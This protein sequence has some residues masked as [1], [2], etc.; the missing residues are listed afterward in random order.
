MTGRQVLKKALMLMDRVD[1]FGEVS[2]RDTADYENKALILLEPLVLELAKA[3]RRDGAEGP[4]SLEEELAVSEAVA[5]RCLAYG[6]AAGLAFT[7]N[8]LNL[9]QFYRGEYERQ[10]KQIPTEE[11]GVLDTFQMLGGMQG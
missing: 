4:V 8:D 2:T 5:A 3:E 7:D 6:L 1:E 10:L 9:F 11:E